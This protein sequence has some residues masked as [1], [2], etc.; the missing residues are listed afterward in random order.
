MKGLESVSG[1][2]ILDHV[3]YIGST[4]ESSPF[5]SKCDRLLSLQATFTRSRHIQ[6]DLSGF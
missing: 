4:G 5:I 3:I 2:R 1:V 6:A